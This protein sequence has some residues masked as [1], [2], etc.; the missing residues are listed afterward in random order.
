MPVGAL[1]RQFALKDKAT[2]VQKMSMAKDPDLAKLWIL[3]SL[4]KGITEYMW[5]FSEEC[6]FWPTQN[7]LCLNEQTIDGLKIGPYEELCFRC[8]VFYA[9]AI[10][11]NPDKRLEKHGR[12]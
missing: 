7:F 8:G 6:P 4:R 10:Y 9:R 12:T 5:H 3:Y 11:A 1:I 2:C